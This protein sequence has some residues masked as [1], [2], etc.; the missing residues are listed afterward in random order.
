VALELA[1]DPSVA[2]SLGGE[3]LQAARGALSLTA[4]VA[5]VDEAARS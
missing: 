4:F 3:A 1:A 2:A 5:A